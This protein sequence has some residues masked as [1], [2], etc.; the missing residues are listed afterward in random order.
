MAEMASAF[1][2]GA[3]ISTLIRGVVGVPILNHLLKLWVRGIYIYDSILYTIVISRGY[4]NPTELE[5]LTCAR[6]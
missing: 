1:G 6:G 5:G 3:S 2:G 4:I